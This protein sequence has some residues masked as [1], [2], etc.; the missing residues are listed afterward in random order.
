MHPDPVLFSVVV[1][2]MADSINNL[3]QL[4]DQG[5]SLV[6]PLTT[7]V[8]CL[9]CFFTIRQKLHFFCLLPYL[10]ALVSIPPPHSFSLSLHF[11]STPTSFHLGE[12]IKVFGL[13][14]HPLV[15][16]ATG[17]NNDA[18]RYKKMPLFPHELG[19]ICSENAN[20]KKISSF[21]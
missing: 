2:E 5:V 6:F 13:A 1:M 16:V 19:A 11:I 4:S 3:E 21:H 15:S 20:G 9:C 10:L 7:V 17:R 14:V 12:L 18:L 8:S